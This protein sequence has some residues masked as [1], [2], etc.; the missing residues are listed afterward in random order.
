ML[1]TLLIT[2]IIGICSGVIG[3]VYSCELT[4]SGMLLDWWWNF[5]YREFDIMNHEQ[6]QEPKLWKV[7]IGCERCV[8]GQISLWSCVGAALQLASNVNEVLLWIFFTAYS[9]SMSIITSQLVKKW[10]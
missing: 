3:Y 10:R 5:L 1:E 9:C 8:S 7:L 4:G 2:S 6:G